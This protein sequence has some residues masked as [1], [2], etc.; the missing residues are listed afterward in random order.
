MG[1]KLTYTFI[2]LI[3]MATM[4]CHKLCVPRKFNFSGGVASVL[5]G[6]DSIRVG[7]TLWFNSSLPV[8]YKYLDNN[9]DSVAYNLSNATNVITDIHFT[10]IIGIQNAIGGV[11]SFS[12]VLPTKGNVQKNPLAPTFAKTISY[13]QENNSY[14]FSFG[15]IA[16]KKGIYCLTII[17]IYQA[18][19]N[20]DKISVDI[21][22]N[23]M[24]NHLHYLKDIY[25]GGGTIDPIDST[26]SYCFKVY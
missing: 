17:D 14:N 21:V 2:V 10:S 1:I 15:I 6:K 16:L 19:K 5:P 11:D 9:S 18:M 7:D 20:C 12:S 23:N 4:S 25:Y 3:L 13:T 22:T 24:D 26:H 8:N